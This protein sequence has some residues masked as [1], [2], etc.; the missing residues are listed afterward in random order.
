M[1]NGIPTVMSKLSADA[2]RISTESNVTCVGED[3]QSFKDCV[4]SIYENEEKWTA[5]Q[6]GGFD[7]IRQTHSVDFI[8]SK[9]KRVID[10]S[11]NIAKD[12]RHNELSRTYTNSE[13][14]PE[15][16]KLY[17]KMYPYIERLLTDHIFT[18]AFEHW[19]EKGKSEGMLYYDC[20]D[21]QPHGL[22]KTDMEQF[23]DVQI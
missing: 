7:F 9:W 17:L 18:S 22:F 2:F 5:I 23:R 15:G 14:C 3:I 16:E 1:S 19:V 8:Q 10:Q 21:D 13:K 20:D 4:I 6:K 11:M 12:L